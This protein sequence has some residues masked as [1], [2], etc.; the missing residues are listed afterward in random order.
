MDVCRSQNAQNAALPQNHLERVQ[1]ASAALHSH[2]GHSSRGRVTY[3][4]ELE[5]ECREDEDVV[6]PEHNRHW[7]GI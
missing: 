5:G 7:S 2:S 3:N 4:A 6:D 1:E